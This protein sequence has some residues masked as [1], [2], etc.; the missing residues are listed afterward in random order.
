MTQRIKNQIANVHDLE[1][2]LFFAVLGLTLV[3][4]AVYGIY[5]RQAIVNV[6]ERESIEKS[7]SL[8]N[9][10]LADL[11]TRYISLKN[12]IDLDIA[13]EKGF[14]DPSHTTFITKRSFSIRHS[15]YE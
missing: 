5:V 7:I 3:L 11:E 9:S 6:V 8:K 2:K 1:K 15:Q 4:S 14:K 13:Y 10:E 12:N